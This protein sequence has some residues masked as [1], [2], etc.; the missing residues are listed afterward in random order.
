MSSCYTCPLNKNSVFFN[1]FMSKR[2]PEEFRRLYTCE[3][4]TRFFNLTSGNGC[5]VKLCPRDLW[6]L[7]YLDDNDAFA[8][9]ESPRV[10]DKLA[11]SSQPELLFNLLESSEPSLRKKLWQRLTSLHFDKL[12]IFCDLRDEVPDSHI[13]FE[14]LLNTEHTRCAA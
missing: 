9:R 4:G 13:M 2:A 11:N 8:I 3:S 7:S 14:T 12:S 6:V 5:S 10:L 1:P